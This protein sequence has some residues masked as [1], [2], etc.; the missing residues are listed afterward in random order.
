MNNREPTHA[1]DPRVLRLLA[2][3]GGSELV[4]PTAQEQALIDAVQHE[5]Q[6]LL[7]IRLGLAQR[8]FAPA[9]RL[10]VLGPMRAGLG[11]LELSAC[12]GLL[13]E[14]RAVV[15]ERYPASLARPAK[16]R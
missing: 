6:Q 1:P 3:Y 14:A 8:W 7:P 11:R 12:R 13:A 10:L 2:R 16:A 5:L 9:A 15:L 4:P